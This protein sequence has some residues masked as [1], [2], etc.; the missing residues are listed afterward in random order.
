MGLQDWKFTI[1][2]A[3]WMPT[4]QLSYT[5]HMLHLPRLWT[6]G[7]AAYVEYRTRDLSTGLFNDGGLV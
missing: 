2:N 5:H 6:T 1:L 7:T 4:A 3:D